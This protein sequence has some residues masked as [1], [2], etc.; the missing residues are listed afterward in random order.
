MD[1]G[2]PA[3]YRIKEKFNQ[4]LTIGWP[5]RQFAFALIVIA[6]IG[7]GQIGTAL[8]E[9]YYTHEVAVTIDWFALARL[10]ALLA[11]SMVLLIVGEMRPARLKPGWAE[12]LSP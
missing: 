10:T 3:L 8:R 2:R 9:R 12:R 7:L 4:S 11:L 5:V 1:T 6:S